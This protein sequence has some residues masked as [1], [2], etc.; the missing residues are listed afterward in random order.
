[1]KHASKISVSDKLECRNRWQ[2]AS[3]TSTAVVALFIVLVAMTAMPCGAQE[4]Q[5]V[6]TPAAQEKT[7]QSPWIFE[8]S[9]YAWLPGVN[10]DMSTGLYS[11]RVNESLIDI[12][13]DTKSIPIVAMGRF[14]AYC[15][16]FGGYLDANYFS[17]NFKDQQVNGIETGLLLQVG[18]LEYALTYAVAGETARDPAQWTQATEMPRFL[19]YGGGRT[20]WL[21]QRIDPAGL[22]GGSSRN[23]LTSPLVGSRA[24]FGISPRWSFMVDGNFGGFNVMDVNLAAEGLGV[25]TYHVRM[26]DLPAAILLGYK[27]LYLDVATSGMLHAANTTMTM[28]GPI[29]GMTISW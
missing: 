4:A 21:K 11:A 8:M 10:A 28:H 5:L 3:A 22:P 2:M 25:F 12:W 13:K 29:I 20:M 16:R 6:E 14:E 17:L 15:K 7:K 27:V 9:F 19:V 18:L 24:V 26:Y 23:T 1:M